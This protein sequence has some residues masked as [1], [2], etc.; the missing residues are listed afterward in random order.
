MFNQR[1]NRR[2]DSRN[3]RISV[4]ELN[5]LSR[6]AQRNIVGGNSMVGIMGHLQRRSS[7]LGGGAMRLAYCKTDAPNSDVITCYLDT[8]GSGEEVEVTCLLHNTTRL[9]YAIPYLNDGDAILVCE[10][11]GTWYSWPYQGVKDYSA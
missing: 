4:R 3:P 10:I 5:S 9:D 11:E 8:D 6:T 2:V 7:S 1:R